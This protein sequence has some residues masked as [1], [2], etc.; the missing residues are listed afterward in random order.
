[1]IEAALNVTTK[2]SVSYHTNK[3]TAFIR[4]PN[5]AEAFGGHLNYCI[6]H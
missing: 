6:V 1:M 2:I 4:N 3:I 5:D